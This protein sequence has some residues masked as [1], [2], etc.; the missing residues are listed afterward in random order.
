M[1]QHLIRRLWQLVQRLGRLLAYRAVTATIGQGTLPGMPQPA[2][3]GGFYYY[4]S[5]NIL[6]YSAVTAAICQLLPQT[7]REMPTLANRLEAPSY[8]KICRI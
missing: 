2:D 3:F 6:A 1:T 7:L 4:Q 5:T 8:S